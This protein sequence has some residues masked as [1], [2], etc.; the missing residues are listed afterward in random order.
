M[1]APASIS[2][3][4]ASDE[5]IAIKAPDDFA[6]V[7]PPSQKLAYG[8]DGV[9]VPSDVWTLTSAMVDFEA[10]GVKP[11]HVILIT[12]PHPPLVQDELLAIDAVN[13]HSATLRRIATAASGLGQPIFPGGMT[14]IEFR[15][16]TLDPQSEEASFQLNRR[17]QIDPAVHGRGPDDLYDLRDL[18]AA[19]VLM[20]LVSR[21]QGIL[22]SSYGGDLQAKLD[23]ARQELAEVMER[24]TIRWTKAG[25]DARST[26]WF[27]T[28]IVR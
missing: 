22:R 7:C 9:I 27:T 12:K 4:Y 5:V 16:A 17:Y 14:G 21:Y 24:L 2:Q 3:T 8:T 19:T 10:A 20:I 1:S 13:G 18:R 26:N 25:D 23:A 28:R 6:M 15:I 11:Q